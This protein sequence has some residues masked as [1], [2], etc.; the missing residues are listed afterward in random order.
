[1]GAN[2]PIQSYSLSDIGHSICV[3]KDGGPSSAFVTIIIRLAVEWNDG[4]LHDKRR[5]VA[6]QHVR[7]LAVTLVCLVI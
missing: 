1:M 3:D 6:D 5:S 7:A 4:N 2:G